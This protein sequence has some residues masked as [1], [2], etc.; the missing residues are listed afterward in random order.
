MQA[1]RRAVSGRSK[2]L[3][4]EVSPL[5]GGGG[6]SGRMA[7]RSDVDLDQRSAS[8]LALLG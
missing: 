2:A 4:G 3:P 1:N 6:H 8:G 7:E 5:Q